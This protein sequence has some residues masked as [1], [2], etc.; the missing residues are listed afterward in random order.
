VG[1][2]RRFDQF[3]RLIQEHI[4]K[5]T[6]ILDVASGKGYLRA[7]LYQL[8]YRNVTCWDK[9]KRA[10]GRKHYRYGYFHWRE[11]PGFGAVVAMHPDAATD[12]AILYAAKNRVPA[13]ICP[14]CI[15]PSAE[16]FWEDY[17]FTNWMNH[18]V[19]LAERNGMEVIKTRLPIQGRNDVLIL[20]P[21]ERNQ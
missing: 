1:D 3:A 2:R 12:H 5:D 8:G 19:R 10:I 9:G 16:P 18:L 7:A 11:K 20:R 6:A 4:N 13:L 15:K 21:K 14:C 17:N